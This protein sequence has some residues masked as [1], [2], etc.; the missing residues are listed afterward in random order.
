MNESH[1]TITQLHQGNGLS[2]GERVWRIVND[3]HLVVPLVVLA[4]GLLL[5]I[6]TAGALTLSDCF[7][8]AS[9]GHRPAVQ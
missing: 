8:R 4:L 9:R 5:V 3:A 1:L 2:V 7:A 6:A